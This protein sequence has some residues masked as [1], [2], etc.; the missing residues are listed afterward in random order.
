MCFAAVCAF[1]AWRSANAPAAWSPAVA[2]AGESTQPEPSWTVR[3]LWLGL[4]ASASV[5]LLAVTTHLTS[6]VA[7]IPFLWIVP[8]VIY[9]LT[10]ILCFEAPVLYQRFFFVPLFLAAA[11][12]M[13]LQ[14]WPSATSSSNPWIS[15]LANL[16]IRTII[17]SLAAS[18]FVVCM[19]CHGELA[20]LKPHPRYLTSFYVTVSL[21]GAIGGLF[22]GMVAPNL[23]R[24]YY[25]F[26]IGLGLAMLVVVAVFA[27]E[28]RRLAGPRRIAGT[29]ALAA[30][31]GCYFWCLGSIMN[32]IVR[33][34][35]VVTRNFYGLL[36]VYD[37]ADP[38][39]DQFAARKLVH[40]VINHGQQMLNQEYRHLPVTYFCPESGIGRAMKATEGKPRKIGIVGL[41]CGTLAAYG[42]K[43]DT[44]RIYEINPLVLDLARTEFT[45]LA[46]T[47]AVIQPALGDGRLVLE[48]EPDQQFDLLVI[49]VFSGDAVPV[50]VIT[51]EAFRLY[52]RH[53]KPDG[54]LAVNISN[55]YLDLEPVMERASNDFQKTGLVYHW[56][57]LD[58]DTMCFACSWTLIMSPAAAAAHPELMKDATVMTPKR[59]FRTWTDDF[60]NMYSIL[61]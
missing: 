53:L 55:K 28:F 36:R 43:G 16:D 26:P 4:S 58:E 29:V 35:R 15:R 7:S 25:E 21:G 56:E 18:L 57:P 17:V 54:I 33:G 24:A 11:A 20:R 30:V 2:E 45:Y 39:K 50:H 37:D 49:D 48:S 61:K 13:A 40:G 9:L 42:R 6:D 60:S 31:L 52:F 38:A 32:Q 27:R 8:L 23:F 59:P 34:Y 47:P 5:L 3:L 46:D 51:R 19:V 44:I 14:L 41:G 12:F 10:F 1:T 22:V